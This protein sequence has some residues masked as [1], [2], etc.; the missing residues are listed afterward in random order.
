[1]FEWLCKPR[2]ILKFLTVTVG[3]IDAGIMAVNL[4]YVHCE[5]RLKSLHKLN[6]VVH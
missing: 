2:R 6:Y 1:M 5:D 4:I 3:V